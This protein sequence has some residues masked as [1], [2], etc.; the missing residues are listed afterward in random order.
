MRGIRMTTRLTETKWRSLH[1]LFNI[2][3]LGAL[4]DLELLERFRFDHDSAGQ[5]AFRNLVERHG[6][7][8]L[9]LCRSMISN[10][11]EVA[12]S[13]SV[14]GHVDSLARSL[15]DVGQRAS[16]RRI[17]HSG[18]GRCTGQRR[19]SFHGLEDVHAAGNRLA[20]GCWGTGHRRKNPAAK[21]PDAGRALEACREVCGA[22]SR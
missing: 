6:P 7:M 1:T 15:V 20:A 3:T 9:G 17:G 2:G 12:R 11:H 14:P 13:S 8:V 19:A 5:E 4:S 16:R 10:P 21:A 22:P 18:V